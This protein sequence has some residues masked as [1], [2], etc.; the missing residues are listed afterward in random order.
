ME[1]HVAVVTGAFGTLGAAVAERLDAQGYRIAAVDL[2][3]RPN[4]P[5]DLAMAFEQVDIADPAT[6]AEIFSTIERRLGAISAL[7]NVAGGFAFEEL[8]GGRVDTW[9][10]MY[11]I[12]L[13]T[14]VVASQA[15]LKHLARPAAIVNVGA[16]ASSRAA[17]GMGAYAA[18]KAGVARLTEALAAELI[19]RQVRVN[20][21]LP[22]IIDT[23]AN[24]QAMGDVDRDLWS[25][26]AELARV[27]AF[28][29]SS[30]A[31]AISGALIPVTRGA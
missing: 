17:A 18:S 28:L 2:G 14:A 20:A 7:V 11:K 13:R 26:P 21:V 27:V 9:D 8:A 12:N 23:P 19:G 5:A 15:A 10:H 29:V 30:D 25:T 22:S 24:R 31:S 1:G 3:R 6:A 4:T 16:A